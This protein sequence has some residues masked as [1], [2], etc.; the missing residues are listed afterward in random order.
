MN[1]RSGIIY[2]LG[3]NRY[4]LAIHSEQDKSFARIKKVFLH[5]FTNKIC[6]IPEL[7]ASGKKVV[8]LKN[9][10]LIKAIGNSD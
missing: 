9:K 10:S 3:N 1:K 4:G 6:N 2:D 8:T 5:V 7:D